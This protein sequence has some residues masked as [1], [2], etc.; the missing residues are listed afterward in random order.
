MAES[1]TQ[2]LLPIPTPLHKVATRNSARLIDFKDVK[3]HITTI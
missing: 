2:E 1:A 3:D